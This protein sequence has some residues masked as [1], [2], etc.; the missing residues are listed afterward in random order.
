[1][2]PHST[3]AWT[4]VVRVVG[5][6]SRS[7]CSTDVGCSF[8][9]HMPPPNLLLLSASTAR[10]VRTSSRRPRHL[11]HTHTHLQ[12]HTTRAFSPTSLPLPTRGP[13]FPLP[14]LHT[15]AHLPCRH[16]FCSEVGQ[17]HCDSTGISRFA[18]NLRRMYDAA[19]FPGGTY[20]ATAPTVT[21]ACALLCVYI[22]HGMI[23]VGRNR[24][25]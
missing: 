16:T 18:G 2:P 6:C 15:Y 23:S 19:A 1:M 11:P 4:S 14:T 17:L 25:V 22:T 20:F 5:L 8:P 7:R 10:V 21:N 3:A 12:Y 9:A 24:L 13:P